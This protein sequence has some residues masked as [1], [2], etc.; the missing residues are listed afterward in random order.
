MAKR[1]AGTDDHLVL[2]FHAEGRPVD[3]L[4]GAACTFLPEAH[5]V[6]TSRETGGTGEP[7][8]AELG[9]AMASAAREEIERTGA[10]RVT[11]IGHSRGADVLAA[12]AIA[13]PGLFDAIAL[14]HPTRPIAGGDVPALAMTRVLVTG[15]KTDDS[16]PPEVTQAIADWFSMQKADVMLAWHPGKHE[17]P[18]SE[19]DTLGDFLI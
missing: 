16:P 15:G 19:V 1:S 9:R 17:I 13:A 18:Q 2:T 4:H 11:G 8:L 12:V 6:S 5:V 10:R 3:Q 7:D 14:L